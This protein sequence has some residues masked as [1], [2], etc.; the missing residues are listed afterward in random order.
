MG[1]GAVN[2]VLFALQQNCYAGVGNRG[3]RARYV[4]GTL[5]NP[6]SIGLG[7]GGGGGGCAT[8]GSGV[9]VEW[10]GTGGRYL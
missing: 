10:I 4:G 3:T 6:I 1:Y 2:R 8:V 9:R 7:G 5:Y